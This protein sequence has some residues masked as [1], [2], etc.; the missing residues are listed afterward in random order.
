M[1]L[2]SRQWLV[3]PRV[4]NAPRAWRRS[5]AAWDALI[6]AVDR[7]PEEATIPYNLA[8]YACQLDKVDEARR[9]FLRAL[10]VGEKGKLKCMASSDP[11]M[12]PLWSEIK[13]L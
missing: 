4:H 1:R 12:K 10:A 3:A 2:G 5:Q 13:G 6:P 9:W 7:F 8:C 11:D